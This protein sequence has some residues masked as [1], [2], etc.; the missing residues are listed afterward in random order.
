MTQVWSDPPT[1]E[2]WRREIDDLKRQILALKTA[3]TLQSSSV[4][5]G[6]MRVNGGRV[7]IDGGSFRVIDENGTDIVFFGELSN[8]SIGWTFRYDDGRALFNRQGLPGQQFWG[9][10]DQSDNIVLSNDAA[11]G[12]GLARPWLPYHLIVTENAE[13]GSSY[14]W[15]STTVST[16]GT[17]LL[18]AVVPIQHPRIRIGGNVLT[19]GGGTGH[20]RLRLRLGGVDTILVDDQTGFAEHTV[21]IPGWGDNIQF[22]EEVALLVDGWVTGGGTRAYVQVDRFYGLGS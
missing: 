10:W 9:F 11:T 8:G 21:T 4:G 16:A 13:Q 18:G 12:V 20:W 1:G 17:H 22:G 15:P 5:A 7:T 6:G 3:L 19:D 14:M 2:P